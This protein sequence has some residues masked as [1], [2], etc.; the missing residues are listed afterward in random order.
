MKKGIYSV[1]EV[2]VAG[3]RPR[4]FFCPFSRQCDPAR[5]MKKV[6]EYYLETLTRT[7]STNGSDLETS[8]LEAAQNP[9]A[10][11]QED[12]EA[13]GLVRR[14]L[15]KIPAAETANRMDPQTLDQAVCRNGNDG[16][17]DKSAGIQRSGDIADVV[18]KPRQ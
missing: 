6:L 16:G 9:G 4:C 5:G 3:G 11:D 18:L 10:G 14:L 15:L 8:G 2:G 17:H 7:G 13:G 12:R 1:D